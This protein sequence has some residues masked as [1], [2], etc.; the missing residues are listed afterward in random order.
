MKKGEDP[1]SKLITLTVTG[2]LLLS[3][4]FNVFA[5]E[6]NNI[7]PVTL[8]VKTEAESVKKP[9]RKFYRCDVEQWVE[10]GIITKEQAEKWK[11]FNKKYEEQRK[12]ELE[13]IRK[14]TKE[15]RRVYFE[16]KKQQKKDYFDELVKEKIITQE[17][18]DKIKEQ[19]LQNH[20]N[21]EKENR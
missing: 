11:E 13:K 5:V 20:Q 12:K 19:I 14:M 15:E 2:G 21:K 4:V 10:Q 17:Q 3:S 8:S 1:L 7:S 9:H 6:T 16:K 18:A